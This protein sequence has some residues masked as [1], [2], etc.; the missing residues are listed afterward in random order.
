MRRLPGYADWQP[1]L[2]FRDDGDGFE[3]L[4]FGECW[5][6]IERKTLAIG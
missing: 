4:V 6:G 3:S 2:P 1:G 5:A